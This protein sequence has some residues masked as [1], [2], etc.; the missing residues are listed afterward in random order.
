M[1]A[2]LARE[3]VVLV[4]ARQPVRR[5]PSPPRRGRDHVSTAGRR[6]ADVDEP[7]QNGPRGLS[8]SDLR[9]STKHHNNTVVEPSFTRS[10]LPAPLINFFHQGKSLARFVQFDGDHAA[11]PPSVCLFSTVSRTTAHDR[12]EPVQVDRV[13]TLGNQSGTCRHAT[14]AT[15]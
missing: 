12:H 7:R 1:A 9:P 6:G 15:G 4:G 10:R 14:A 8:A 5:P 3:D 2:G 11:H 13:Q